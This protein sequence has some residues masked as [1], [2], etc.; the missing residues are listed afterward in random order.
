MI[1]EWLEAGWLEGEVDITISDKGWEVIEEGIMLWEN[2]ALEFLNDTFD[3]AQDEGHFHDGTRGGTLFIDTDSVEQMEKFAK[4]YTGD[5]D[6]MPPEYF[7]EVSI[8]GTD[9]KDIVYYLVDANIGFVGLQT[10][11]DETLD[12]DLQ[13]IE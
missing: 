8:D 9:I 4:Y 10:D 11:S 12:L 7:D 5:S 1:K 13:P 3:G 2:I 6:T